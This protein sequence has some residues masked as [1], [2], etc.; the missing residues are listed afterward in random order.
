MP[1]N[2]RKWIIIGTMTVA[3]SVSGGTL[4][5][6]WNQLT[7]ASTTFQA[8]DAFLDAL[9][10]P[11]EE[12][13]HDALIEGESLASIAEAHGGDASAL[14]ELQTSE[15]TALQE[16]RYLQG[17]ISAE[18]LHRYTAEAREIITS[19]TFKEWA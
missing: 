8:T 1:M 3:I 19:S 17:E 10:T 18:Q 9:G 4:R 14:I 15:L 13:L 6:E 11:T 5:E 7:A 16:W 12:E 2:I